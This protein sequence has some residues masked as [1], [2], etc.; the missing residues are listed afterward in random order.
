MMYKT[1]I[2]QFNEECPFM[3]YLFDEIVDKSNE[4]RLLELL[5]WYSHKFFGKAI[6]TILDFVEICKVEKMSKYNRKFFTVYFHKV[7]EWYNKEMMELNL[8][9]FFHRKECIKIFFSQII[10]NFSGVEK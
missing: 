4:R 6:L 2:E 7:P 10:K 8:Y 5:D 1:I 3:R 9:Y